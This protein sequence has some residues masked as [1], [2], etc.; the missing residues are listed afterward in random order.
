MEDDGSLPP[1][2]KRKSRPPRRHNPDPSSHSNL[3]NTQQEPVMLSTID[4]VSGLPTVEN[5]HKFF[6]LSRG[7]LIH[8]FKKYVFLV[9]F[10]VSCL[11]F[12]CSS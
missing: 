6:S 7:V 1:K 9:F 12:M 4:D 8:N 3:I 11:V 2:A 10:S 5:I